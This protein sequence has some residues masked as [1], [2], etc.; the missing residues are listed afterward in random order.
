[1]KSKE[2]FPSI[3]SRHARSYHEQ[4]TEL[5]RARRRVLELAAAR[6]GERA[7][8]LACGPGTLTLP[9]AEAVGPEGR[10]VGVD[11]ATGMLDV[12][13]A[14]APSWV[15]TRLADIAV[16]EVPAASFDVVTCGHG[17]QFL[18]DLPP[19]LREARRVLAAGGRFAASVPVPGPSRQDARSAVTEVLDR[20]APPLEEPEDR[21]ETFALLTDDSR[22]CSVLA[23]AGF[24]R[25]SV[26]RVEESVT[27]PD[28]ETMVAK[29]LS[30]WGHQERLDRLPAAR[31]AEAVEK[32]RSALRTEVPPEPHV[33]YNTVFFGSA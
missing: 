6:P 20:L 16:L 19:A 10:V 31:R 18:P 5:P 23:S 21:S 1:M 12:L 17:Y 22:L 13:R 3:F 2:F 30:W 26:E 32:V 29:T 27:Y 9:I 28:V 33:I 25:V 14:R 8:D 24:S 15:E 4:Q 11:L 7:L